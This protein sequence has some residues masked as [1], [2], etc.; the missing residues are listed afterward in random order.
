MTSVI[1]LVPRRNNSPFTF[2]GIRYQPVEDDVGVLRMEVGDPEYLAFM[3]AYPDVFEMP[4]DYVA[5]KAAEEAAVEEVIA[6]EPAD[7]DTKPT[8]VATPKAKAKGRKSQ[9]G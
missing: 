3:S 5:P 1:V 4:H 2:N 7:A 9:L 6:A 8:P